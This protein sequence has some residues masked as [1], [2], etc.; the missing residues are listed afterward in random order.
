[1]HSPADLTIAEAAAGLRSGELT[2]KALTEAHLERIAARD[3]NYRAF[4]TVTVERALSDAVRADTDLAS[5]VD[6]G[7]LHGIPVAVKD[8]IDTAGIRTA[9]GSRLRETYVPDRDAAVIT[10][11]VDGGAV[12]LGKLATYEL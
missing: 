12:L 11:L 6:H 5:G 4:V 7:P 8:I 3:K 10:R 9:A 2:S 1:M